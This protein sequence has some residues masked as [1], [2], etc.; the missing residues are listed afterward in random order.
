MSHAHLQQKDQTNFLAFFAPVSGCSGCAA[1]VAKH[2][3]A[4]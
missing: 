1:A 2:S 3:F 4:E